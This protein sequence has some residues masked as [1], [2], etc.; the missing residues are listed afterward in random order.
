MQGF[1]LSE[2]SSCSRMRHYPVKWLQLI[3]LCLYVGC[4]P[5]GGLIALYLHEYVV[6]VL[7]TAGSGDRTRTSGRS[8]FALEVAQE[9]A[10]PSGLISNSQRDRN[11]NFRGRELLF[12]IQLWTALGI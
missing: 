6:G 7:S 10:G 5:F 4:C 9:Q 1:A 11:T 8:G 12:P 2:R 3:S